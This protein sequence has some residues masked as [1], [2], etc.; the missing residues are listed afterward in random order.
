MA[1]IMTIPPLGDA[2]ELL[3]DLVDKLGLKVSQSERHPDQWTITFSTDLTADEKTQIE[4]S[5]TKI[6][7]G[8]EWS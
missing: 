5:V 4:D 6:M 2:W 1:T 7:S 3:K 8:V